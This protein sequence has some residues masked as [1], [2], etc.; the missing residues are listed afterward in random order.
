M[1]NNMNVNISLNNYIKDATSATKYTDP[2][3]GKEYYM[4]ECIDGRKV[5]VRVTVT[6]MTV[7]KTPKKQNT[8]ECIE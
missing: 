3:D 7:T 1:D 4:V 6:A 8:E 5:K 2:F